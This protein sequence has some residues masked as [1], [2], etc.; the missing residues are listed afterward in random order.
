M[1]CETVEQANKEIGRLRSYLL[2]ISLG[3]GA[4][5]RDHLEH[6]DNCIRDMK[7]Q[8][9]KALRGDPWEE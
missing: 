4:Y 1:I 8:A 7:A 2:E 9:V 6:A 3:R 5:S